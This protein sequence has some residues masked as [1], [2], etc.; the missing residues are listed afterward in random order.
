MTGPAVQSRTASPSSE[1]EVPKRR[2]DDDSLSMISNTHGVE[3]RAD[4]PQKQV[5]II[6]NSEGE[7]D[8]KQTKRNSTRSTYDQHSN[9]TISKY[10]NESKDSDNE[11]KLANTVDLTNG[12]VLDLLPI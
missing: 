2:R 5:K 6:Q 3:P 1:S 11:L 9:R 4:R 8:E 7:S 10:M 12:K